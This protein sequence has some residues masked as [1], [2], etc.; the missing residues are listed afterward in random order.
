MKNKELYLIL[1][2]N[3]ENATEKMGFG[4]MKGHV[5][6]GTSLDAHI[7]ANELTNGDCI[8]S[9]DEEEIRECLGTTSVIKLNSSTSVASGSIEGSDLYDLVLEC[10]NPMDALSSLLNTLG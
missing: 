4:N 6:E 5:I 10:E 3:P 9:I 8:E 2:S 1:L 7:K